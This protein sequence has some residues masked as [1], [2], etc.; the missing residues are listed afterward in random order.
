MIPGEIMRSNVLI[1][2]YLAPYDSRYCGELYFDG[3]RG[4][5]RRDRDA[6]WNGLL[7]PAFGYMWPIVLSLHYILTST[8]LDRLCV[9]VRAEIQ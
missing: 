7:R 8:L 3:Y 9:D 6:V 4:Y 5:R 1:L 2:P